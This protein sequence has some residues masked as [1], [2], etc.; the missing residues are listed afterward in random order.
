MK[1]IPLKIMLILA[2]FTTTLSACKKS[3]QSGTA[4]VIYSG[5][6]DSDGCGWLV[7]LNSNNTV[8]AAPGLSQAYQRQNLTITIT[9]NVES[10]KYQ[11]G[12]QSYSEIDILSIK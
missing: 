3:E 9:Y 12:G 5:S 1:K 11:C 6:L 8:Y 10:T 7:R 2:L 4:T